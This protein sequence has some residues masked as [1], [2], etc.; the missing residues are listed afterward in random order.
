LFLKI[1]NTL[2]LACGP[3][4]GW[5]RTTG[6]PWKLRTATLRTLIVAKLTSAVEFSEDLSF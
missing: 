4:D 5:L 1:R 2:G 3:P 6:G